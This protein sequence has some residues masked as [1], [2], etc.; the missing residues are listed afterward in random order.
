[1]QNL[2]LTLEDLEIGRQKA[3]ANATGLVSDAEVLIAN[4]CWARALF[5]AQIASEEIG[6]YII[7]INAAVES[8]E[9]AVDWKSFWQSYR[10][11]STKLTMVMFTEIMFSPQE[12]GQEELKTFRE[13]AKYLEAGKMLSLYSDFID[14]RFVLPT[15]CIN[16]EMAKD[17]VKWAKGRLAMTNALLESIV[18][19]DT[20]TTGGIARSKDALRNRLKDMGAT[21]EMLRNS[22]FQ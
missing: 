2:A 19:L 7:I 9:K 6:K 22:P 12:N 20:L 8:L 11:H 10:Q 18:S 17:A 5:L 15:D 16:P 3:L 4:E 1:M 13:A 14:G 21:D